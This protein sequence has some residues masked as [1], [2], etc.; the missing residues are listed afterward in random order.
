MELTRSSYYAMLFDLDQAAPQRALADLYRDQRLPSCQIVAV[1][2][3]G[4]R[5]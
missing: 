3:C 5:S 1:S 4:R 2:P